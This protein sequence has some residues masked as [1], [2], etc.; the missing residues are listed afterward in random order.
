MEHVLISRLQIIVS[1]ELSGPDL[2]GG[3]NGVY[4]E[5]GWAMYDNYKIELGNPADGLA[6]DREEGM[7]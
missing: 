3:H 2:M 6:K 4:I 7:A 5:D 1:Y